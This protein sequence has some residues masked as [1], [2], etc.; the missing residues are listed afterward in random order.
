MDGIIDFNIGINED[1]FPDLIDYISNIPESHKFKYFGIFTDNTENQYLI[2]DEYW[3]L[4]KGLIKMTERK[5][6]I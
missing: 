4:I 5:L 2:P 1:V 3:E 6:D